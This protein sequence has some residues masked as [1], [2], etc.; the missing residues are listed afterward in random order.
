MQL[1]LYGGFLV[2][3][4]L[5]FTTLWQR[6]TLRLRIGE[7]AQIALGFAIPIL[8]VR[9]VRSPHIYP[10]FDPRRVAGFSR[11]VRCACLA[12]LGSYAKPRQSFLELAAPGCRSAGD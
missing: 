10:M 12:S 6:R 5:A 2:H 7:L 8:L 1:L 9:H 11:S 3:Y 4:G